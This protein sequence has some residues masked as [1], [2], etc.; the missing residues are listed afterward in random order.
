MLT[1]EQMM[2]RLGRAQGGSFSLKLED[3]GE[4]VFG[5][6]WDRLF[7][8]EVILDD[9]STSQEEMK[10][11][12]YGNLPDFPDRSAVALRFQAGE[13]EVRGMVVDITLSRHLLS[14]E[15]RN[16]DINSLYQRYPFL[17]DA[18][19][20]AST[21]EDWEVEQWIELECTFPDGQSEFRVRLEPAPQGM[22]FTMAAQF[23]NGESPTFN[24]SQPQS[25]PFIPDQLSTKIADLNPAELA[26][27]NCQV[28]EVSLRLDTSA[29]IYGVS[30][31]LAIGAQLQW[32]F[33]DAKASFNDAS[34]E[35]STVYVNGSWSASAILSGKVRIMGIELVGMVALPDLRYEFSLGFGTAQELSSDIAQALP[36]I[37]SAQL[38]NA[39]LLGSWRARESRLHVEVGGTWKA[40]EGVALS[41][42]GADLF[43]DS[44]GVASVQVSG[45]FLLGDV[46]LTLSASKTASSWRLSGIFQDVDIRKL[47]ETIG[48]SLPD[49]LSELNIDE[50]RLDALIAPKGLSFLCTGSLVVGGME[51]RLAVSISWPSIEVKLHSEVILEES[52]LFLDGSATVQGFLLS[53]EFGQPTSV[54]QM[55]KSFGIAK[56]SGL[57]AAL[58]VL[59]SLPSLESISIDYRRAS[60]PLTSSSMAVTAKAVDVTVGLIAI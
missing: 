47:C 5:N 9:C 13:S 18:H 42:I 28:R 2:D 22:G 58:S 32:D 30:M 4:A 19:L 55:L 11:S 46:E 60:P 54:S 34:V 26:I 45:V 57:D 14:G 16:L 44:S 10:V 7:S 41:H 40:W 12:G 50:C 48:I 56:D 15:M 20:L 49:S 8:D 1:V 36:A 23:Q 38:L 17:G 37:E 27:P 21:T 3:L 33:M 31:K 51:F 29:K 25:I 24:M 6:I 53:G 39:T 52:M 59:D 35:I 43:L